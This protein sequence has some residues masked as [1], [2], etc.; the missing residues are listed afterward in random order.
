MQSSWVVYMLQCRDGSFYTGITNDIEKRLKEHCEGRGSRY[1]RSRMP[2]ELV[3][4]EKAEDRPSA[5]RREAAI[6]KL[7][8]PEKEI[9]VKH[10][11]NR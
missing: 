11:D 7:K 5:L 2:F 6:K 1:V 8:R 4:S 9:L 10:N 3:F